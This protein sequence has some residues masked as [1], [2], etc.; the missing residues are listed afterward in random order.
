MEQTQVDAI[1]ASTVAWLQTTSDGRFA[2]STLTPISGGTVNFSY[3]AHLESPLRDGTEEVFVKHSEEFVRH[4]PS[5]K[6]NL[7]RVVGPAR[8]Q[9]QNVSRYEQRADLITYTAAE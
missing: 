1:Q 5:F 8:L 3:R 6:V 9:L 4:T 2:A 7:Q